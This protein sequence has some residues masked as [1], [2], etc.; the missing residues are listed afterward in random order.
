MVVLK[1]ST[2]SWNWN[3]KLKE[4]LHRISIK[5]RVFPNL[6]A[7]AEIDF[8]SDGI[9]SFANSNLYERIATVF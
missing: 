2:S 6:D 9:P 8:S 3:W 4:S 7:D 5:I 1:T